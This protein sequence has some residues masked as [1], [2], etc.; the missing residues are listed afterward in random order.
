LCKQSRRASKRSKTTWVAGAVPQNFSLKKTLYVSYK[1]FEGGSGLSLPFQFIWQN[2]QWLTLHSFDWWKFEYL[3]SKDMKEI[4]RGI[5]SS[6][7]RNNFGK[8]R[9][10]D[11]V[12]FINEKL[13]DTSKGRLHLR[14]RYSVRSCLQGVWRAL[15][16]TRASYMWEFSDVES[17]TTIISLED[18]CFMKIAT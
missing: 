2:L 6:T 14:P 15:L 16:K 10:V 17:K 18:N 13:S 5:N 12:E 3:S 8:P 9:V 7:T 4:G 11:Q 1:I